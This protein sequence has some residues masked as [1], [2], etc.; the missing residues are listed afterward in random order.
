MF[1]FVCLF[2]SINEQR[3]ANNSL[4]AEVEMLKSSLDQLK[5]LNTTLLDEHTA[6][7]LAFSSLEEKLRGVQV[8][9]AVQQTSVRKAA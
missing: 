2:Y 3:A 5:K 8:S 6:L 9:T 4:R 1:V 7:Q